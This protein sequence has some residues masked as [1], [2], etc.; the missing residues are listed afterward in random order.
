MSNKNIFH[1]ACENNNIELIKD[2]IAKGFDCT[3]DDNY[4]IRW[5]SYY[6]HLEIV[7]LLLENGAD[8][9]ACYNI[10]RKKISSINKIK[11]KD[12][13]TIYLLDNNLIIRWYAEK[14]LKELEKNLDI[15]L[16]KN[17]N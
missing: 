8:A 14:K 2:Y 13:L 17:I 4:T 11:K 15:L 5:A 1:K 16:Y 9:K 6:Y 3:A 7:K 12:S 10:D